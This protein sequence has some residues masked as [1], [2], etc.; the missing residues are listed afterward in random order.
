MSNTQVMFLVVG[1]FL[2]SAVVLCAIVSH[3]IPADYQD[4][5]DPTYGGVA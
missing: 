5:D 3:E 4:D 1:L 2:V